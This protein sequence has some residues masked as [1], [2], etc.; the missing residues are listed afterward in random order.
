M[1]PAPPGTV[2]LGLVATY[3]R[4]KGHDVFLEAAARVNADINA[5]FYIIGGPLYRSSGSQVDPGALRAR[6]DALRLSDRLGFISHQPDPEAVYRALD[7]VVHASTKPE[8]F[9]RVIVEAMACGCAVIVAHGGGAAELFEDGISAIGCPPGDPEAL[10]AAMTRLI[11]SPDLRHDLGAGGR[12]EAVARFDR[13]ERGLPCG[14]RGSD[15]RRMIRGR[16]SRNAELVIRHLSSV[17]S[18]RPQEQF[19]EPDSSS[20]N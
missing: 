11:A 6:A 5:R 3:A 8:P 14:Q 17:I 16:R 9:G 18:H 4:W 12:A 10:A 20:A 19:N 15:G 7:V 2:R 13:R 1:T